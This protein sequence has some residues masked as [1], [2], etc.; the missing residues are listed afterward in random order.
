MAKKINNVVEFGNVRNY[1]Y[2][3][4]VARP[5]V[6]L[7]NYPDSKDSVVVGVA[8]A[9]EILEITEEISGYGKTSDGWIAIE[10]TIKV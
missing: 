8:K 3:V 4:E 6:N 7:R 1:P 10:Y 2:N 5:L 9:G